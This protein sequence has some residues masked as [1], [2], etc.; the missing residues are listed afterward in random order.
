MEIYIRKTVCEKCSENLGYGFLAFQCFQNKECQRA[1]RGYF[2]Q[3]C[4]KLHILHIIWG[5][6]TL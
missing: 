3:L 1:E 2:Q 5:N 6:V 4:G